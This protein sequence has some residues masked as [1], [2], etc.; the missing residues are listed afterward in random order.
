MTA[1]Y[2]R[3]V[4]SVGW[5]G[6]ISQSPSREKFRFVHGRVVPAAETITAPAVIA[7]QPMMITW[8][9]VDGLNLPLL[10]GR[11]FVTQRGVVVDCRRNRLVIGAQD[12]IMRPSKNGHFFVGLNP[13]YVV[14]RRWA[15]EEYGAQQPFGH[16]TYR[17][18]AVN[19]PSPHVRGLRPQRAA[20]ARGA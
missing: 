7:K 17:S 11:D 2:L 8:H 16:A 14:P 18:H 6:L 15:V 3:R 9:S 20:G 5:G 19:S 10:L 1:D 13:D 12:E 4:R